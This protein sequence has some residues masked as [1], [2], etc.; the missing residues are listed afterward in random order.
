MYIVYTQILSYSRSTLPTPPLPRSFV[1]SR[2]WC[3]MLEHWSLLENRR[4]ISSYLSWFLLSISANRAS[5]STSIWLRRAC[6]LSSTLYST[7]CSI[8]SCIRE[9]MEGGRLG[10]WTFPV[11]IIQ[12]YTLVMS[13]HT[14]LLVATTYNFPIQLIWTLPNP[15]GAYFFNF[16][17]VKW[18]QAYKDSPN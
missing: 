3:G 10:T 17:L 11:A 18:E 16:L 2:R 6:T 14:T 12:L 5:I 8:W 1:G 4:I 13:L 7:L 15:L 9:R